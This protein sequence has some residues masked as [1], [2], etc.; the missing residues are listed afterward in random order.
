MR[1]RPLPIAE[2]FVASNARPSLGHPGR[3]VP[4]NE[5]LP[6]FLIPTYHSRPLRHYATP[7]PESV[8]LNNLQ[9]S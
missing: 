4:T 2:A 7:S 6:L 3:E 8:T 5:A 1:R 9:F